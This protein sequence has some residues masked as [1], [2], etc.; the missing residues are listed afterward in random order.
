MKRRLFN[1][2]A[3]ASLLM[4][5]TVALTCVVGREHTIV[6]GYGGR[7]GPSSG[8]NEWI[9]VFDGRSVWAGRT[10]VPPPLTPGRRSERGLIFRQL[11]RTDTAAS[12]RDA[13]KAPSSE[14]TYAAALGFAIAN[15]KP[16]ASAASLAGVLVPNWFLLALSVLLPSRWFTLYHGR[17]RRQRLAAA[18]LCVRCGYDLRATGDRCPECGSAVVRSFGSAPHPN[19]LP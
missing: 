15:G 5:A 1:A 3:V 4:G 19:A 18:G 10:R 13:F 7:A 9:L 6:A 17:W 2:V 11:G 16:F 8:T 12:L 14:N